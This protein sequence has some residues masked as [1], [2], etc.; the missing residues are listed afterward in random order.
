MERY[1]RSLATGGLGISG[2]ENAKGMLH[3]A[4]RLAGKW[5]GGIIPNPVA[6]ADLPRNAAQ[7][8][9]VRAPS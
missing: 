4:A 6:L 5:S 2:I 9:P 3:K 1:F 7:S 8:E